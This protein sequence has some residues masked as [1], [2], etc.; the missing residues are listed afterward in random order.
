MK[1]VFRWLWLLIVSLVLVACSTVK[2]ASA[3]SQPSAKPTKKTTARGGAYFQ[4]DGPASHIPVNLDLVPNAVPQD[5]PLI[6][7]ANLPYTAMGMSFR[8]DTSPAPYRARGKASWYGRQFHGRRTTSGERY[9]MFAMTAAHPTLPIPSYARVTNL[10]NGKSVVVRIN[11]R[12]PFHRGRLLDLSYAAA[13]RLS[14][15]GQ[16][17]ASVLV[18]RVWPTEGETTLTARN[19]AGLRQDESP[20][21]LQL[22]AFNSL[23]NAEAMLKKLVDELDKGYDDKLGIVNQQG[24]YRV[25]LGP[26]SSDAAVRTAAETLNVETIVMNN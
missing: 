1:P 14:F 5:E 25:R 6:R 21:Y 19:D 22:G 17:S 12:G 4:N 8:P 20:K 26:F 16:G 3:T 18:E 13:H 2:T 10:D 23:A 24:V 9:D 11:D 7:A 15:V